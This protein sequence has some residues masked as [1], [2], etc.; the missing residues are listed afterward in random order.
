MSSG[1]GGSVCDATIAP[2]GRSR[3]DWP[4]LLGSWCVL[5]IWDSNPSG[6]TRNRYGEFRHTSTLRCASVFHRRLN[7]EVEISQKR[8]P[9]LIN[10]GA[11]PV[12]KRHLY[13]PRRPGLFS[14]ATILRIST[15]ALR[16]R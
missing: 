12:V 14:V 8:H 5:V 15:F 9:T 4:V 1:F 13:G 7:A 11:L 6:I 10:P 3:R 16:R 2:S